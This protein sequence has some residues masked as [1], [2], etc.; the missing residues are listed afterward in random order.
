M[1]EIISCLPKVE[2]IQQWCAFYNFRGLARPHSCIYQNQVAA[3]A[4]IKTKTTHHTQRA[5]QLCISDLTT[6]IY[7]FVT[8]RSVYCEV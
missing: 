4:K 1:V 5:G 8:S 7:T 2:Q 3:A 6:I